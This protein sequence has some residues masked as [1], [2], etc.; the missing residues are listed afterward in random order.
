MDS[1]IGRKDLD[2]QD[3]KDLKKRLLGATA[4]IG[5][6]IG[7]DFLTGSLLNPATVASTK[8]LSILAYAG[9]NG[10]QGAYTNYLVQKHLYGEENV[11][12]GEIIS[13]GALSAVPFMNL[14]AGKNVANIVGDANTLRRGIVG[15]AGF[16]LAGEQLRVGIDEKEFL[17]PIEASMAIALGGGIG[18]AFKLPGA[19]QNRRMENKLRPF[20]RNARRFIRQDGTYDFEAAQ[21][22]LKLANLSSRGLK[23]KLTRAIDSED[24][25]GFSISNRIQ[26]ALGGSNINRALPPNATPR[27]TGS[28]DLLDNSR[29]LIYRQLDDVNR[30]E[31]ENIISSI[32][33]YIVR[34]EAGQLPGWSASRPTFAFPGK[35][36]L[37]YTKKDGTQSEM[38]F[39]WSASQETIN[40]KGAIVPYDVPAA[41][42][43]VKKRYKW[44][45]PSSVLKRKQRNLKKGK[46][47]IGNA[48]YDAYMKWL[49]QNDPELYFRII[50]DTKSNKSGN[51]WYVEHLVAQ[52]AK[53]WEEGP[54]GIFYHKF[55]NYA[56]GDPENMAPIFD[57]MLGRTKTALEKFIYS[58]RYQKL[59]G[60]HFGSTNLA[61]A[62][63]VDFDLEDLIIRSTYDNA[64][65]YRISVLTNPD[66]LL[67]EVRY[68]IKRPDWWVN[69]TEANRLARLKPK[70]RPELGITDQTLKKETR[71]TPPKS[72]EEFEALPDNIQDEIEESWEYLAKADKYY[73]EDVEKFK[74][75]Y[76]SLDD[77]NLRRD[78]EARYDLFKDKV[79]EGEINEQ[80]LITGLDEYYI[81]QIM[82]R[83]FKASREKFGG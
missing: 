35:K 15:G 67:T 39:R 10:F 25:K 20:K 18:G 41:E 31:A 68:A 3:N 69:E 16:G 37:Q 73:G 72:V 62:H 77:P 13:S 22:A 46:V 44:D 74:S 64:E 6:G 29:K 48:N 30:N 40:G 34:G 11:R 23:N 28:L 27:L 82:I 49:K 45:Q 24:Y 14:K 56:A 80:L 58:K 51:P 70:K 54:D 76:V 78:A 81:S 47:T 38:G 42:A 60:K 36:T 2:L 26:G 66:D 71:L 9:I 57:S 21:R 4:E 5:G 65:I 53:I 1:N 75:P 8:G 17:D 19:I 55:R 63:Y 12:W 33:G 83:M 43:L 61:D 52:K 59:H 50:E 79:K 32:E 7:I